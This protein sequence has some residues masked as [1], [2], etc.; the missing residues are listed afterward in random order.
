MVDPKVRE[1]TLQHLWSYHKRTITCRCQMRPFTSAIQQSY[2][3]QWYLG[4]CLKRI[5]SPAREAPG[6]K[7]ALLKQVKVPWFCSATLLSVILREA[8]APVVPKQS[9]LQ[10]YS[11]VSIWSR[12]LRSRDEFLYSCSRYLFMG[13]IDWQMSRHFRT[14][15]PR[16]SPQHSPR[17]PHSP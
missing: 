16:V 15:S 14:S 5:A 10:R 4:V 12:S 7:L 8:I 2:C 9:S 3:I 6:R 11:G 13:H 1:T 17:I